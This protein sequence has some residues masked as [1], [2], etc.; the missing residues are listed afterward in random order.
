VR[1]IRSIVEC[2]DDGPLKFAYKLSD[3]ALD[4]QGIDSIKRKLYGTAVARQEN[5][6]ADEDD[7]GDEDE[8]DA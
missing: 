1:G 6:D 2:E 7:D 3:V 4:E 8:E 5:E